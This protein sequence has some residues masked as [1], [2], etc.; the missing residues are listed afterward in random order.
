VLGAVVIDFGVSRTLASLVAD[1][2]VS[3]TPGYLAPEQVSGGA[4]AKTDVYALAA[5]VY[6]LLAGKPLFAH[7]PTF[8]ARVLAHAAQAPFDDP[9]H[10]TALAGA[11]AELVSLLADATALDPERRP[12]IVAFAER[13][14]AL[15]T[16]LG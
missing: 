4:H 1:G 5:S 14:A 13:F 6:R 2:A 10:T 12:S 16:S 15:G 7:C 3:G 9:V 8:G 11:P